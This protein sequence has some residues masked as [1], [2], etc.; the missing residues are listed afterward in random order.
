MSFP[1]TII[2][3]THSLSA[4]TPSWDGSCGFEQ[5]VALDYA[6]CTTNTKFRVQH[7]T[8]HAGIGTHID[9]PAHCFEGSTTVDALALEHLIA[10]CAVIDISD[11]ADQIY[12]LSTD[13]IETFEK[14]HGTIQPQSF[15]IIR[16]G[17]E[18]F[19]HE[20]ERYRNNH[21]FPSV[22]LA[23]AHVLLKRDVVGL[24]IDTLGFDRPSD[25]YVVH[26][27]VLGAGKYL[28]ENVA[29]AHHLP[30]VGS[31]S[32]ALPIKTVGGTEAPMRLIALIKK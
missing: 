17:W 6:N 24:G 13:D 1:F 12:S 4:T 10:P 5:S 31:Y 23:A 30:R 28:V 14:Q 15:V 16:T 7:I 18:Q 29:N 21:Q 19:W 25:N 26:A 9:A 32:I 2:D 3:L 20:P 11:K 8:M 27:T 22:S